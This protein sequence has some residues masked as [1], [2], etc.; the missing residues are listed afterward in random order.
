MDMNILSS[1]SNIEKVKD[2]TG[3]IAERTVTIG[4]AVIS[5]DNIGTLAVIE[6]QKNNSTLVFA[7]LFC[8]AG[9]Y[10]ITNVGSFGLVLLLIGCVVGALWFSVMPDSFL[11]IGTCDGRQTQIVSK[12]KKFLLNIQSALKTKIDSRTT[13]GAVI[14]V[15]TGNISGALVIGDRNLTSTS[16]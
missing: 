7:V 13:D 5:V 6:G 4:N 12:D 16:S 2:G 8:L 15:S 3:V 14:N 1:S 10:A 9:L 11:Q